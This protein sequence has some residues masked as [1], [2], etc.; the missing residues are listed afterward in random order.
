MLMR[1]NRRFR[2]LWDSG[3]LDDVLPMVELHSRLREVVSGTLVRRHGSLLFERYVA[4]SPDLDAFQDATGWEA[5]VNH[6][7]VEE[8]LDGVGLKTR[9]G[10]Q[11][12]VRQGVKAAMELSRRL[13]GEGVFRVVLSF[14]DLYVASMAMRFYGL[15]EGVPYLQEDL[16]SYKFDAILTIDVG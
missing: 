5:S 12:L 7:H 10:R 14:S 16:E 3:R 13:S 4:G 1:M 2:T 11:L 6:F 15:R 8:M 9:H